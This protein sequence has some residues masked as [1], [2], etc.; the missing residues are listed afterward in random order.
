MSQRQKTSSKIDIEQQE[1]VLESARE[2]VAGV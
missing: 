2:I 1:I